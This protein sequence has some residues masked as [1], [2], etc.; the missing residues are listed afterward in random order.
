MAKTI[1]KHLKHALKKTHHFATK[2]KLVSRKTSQRTTQIVIVLILAACTGSLTLF[3]SS[4]RATLSFNLGPSLSSGSRLAGPTPPPEP[5]PDQ[6][7]EASWYALGLPAP[8][9]LTCASTKFGRGSYLEVKN[10]RN[11]KTVTCRVNDYGPEAWTH[12]A[13]DLS[14]GSFRV[15]EDL[16]RGTAPV[17]IR[18]VSSPQSR[19]INIPIDLGQ[20]VGYQ[21]CHAHH[22]A[23]YCEFMRQHGN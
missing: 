8:D 20:V 15:I 5:G 10:L 3:A 16:G 9:T 6:V 22:N 18:L 11:G 14:R 1:T 23:W 21:F 7:G 19:G 17:E 12:R 2:R 4:R 13:V